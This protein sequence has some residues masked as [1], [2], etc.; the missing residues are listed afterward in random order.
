M[1]GRLRM[2]VEQCIDAYSNLSRKV[3]SKKSLISIPFSFRGNFRA[4]YDTSKLA[5]AVKEIIEESGLDVDTPL[6]DGEDR[7]CRV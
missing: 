1:L 7:G 3:F 6:N 5:A 4:K 2:D